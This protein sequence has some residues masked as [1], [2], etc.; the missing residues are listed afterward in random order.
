MRDFYP[1][2]SFIV[3]SLREMGYWQICQSGDLS[4]SSADVASS[5][6]ARDPRIDD[7]E[8]DFISSADVEPG[9]RTAEGGK[10]NSLPRVFMIGRLLR[11]RGFYDRYHTIRRRRIMHSSL[12]FRMS[13]RCRTSRFHCELEVLLV[14]I[15]MQVDHN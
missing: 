11:R 15:L 8:A 14:V 13:R 2:G 4:L 6:N 3:R 10:V 12:A 7:W 1:L 9:L 5:H